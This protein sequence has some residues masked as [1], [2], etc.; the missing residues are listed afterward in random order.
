LWLFGP[1]AIFAAVVLRTAEL[2]SL[3]GVFSSAAP[4]GLLA[5]AFTVNQSALYRG[6]FRVFGTE[7]ALGDAVVLSLV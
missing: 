6:V 7:M 4:A 5:A 1:T 3:R 2:S